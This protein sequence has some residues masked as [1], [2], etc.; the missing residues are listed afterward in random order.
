M[1]NETLIIIGVLFILA[2]LLYVIERSN[3]KL[4]DLVPSAVVQELIRTAVNT[5]LDA[6]GATVAATPTLADDE[7]LKLIREEVAKL[8]SPP[9]PLAALGSVTTTTTTTTPEPPAVV[10]QRL[11]QA[12]VNAA[13]ALG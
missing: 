11:E 12:Y 13:D 6:A 1:T 5:A 7:L 8:L 10:N 4:A 3:R 9:T 2:A